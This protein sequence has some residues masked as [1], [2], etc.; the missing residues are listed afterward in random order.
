M[1]I[2]SSFLF[3][4]LLFGALACTNPEPEKQD[5]LEVPTHDSISVELPV[6]YNP[7]PSPLEIAWM[8]KNAGLPYVEGI[9]LAPDAKTRF[10]TSFQKQLGLGVYSAD[11]TYCSL[12]M[13]EQEAENYFLGLNELA[14]DIGFGETLNTEYNVERMR[15][16]VGDIDSVAF[17]L[18][19]IHMNTNRYF[20]ENNEMEKS[21]VIFSGAWIESMYLGATT[22]SLA[23][24][25]ELVGLLVEQEIICSDIIDG[26]EKATPT[27]NPQ[28]DIAALLEILDN[29]RSQLAAITTSENSEE[30]VVSKEKLN[31]FIV[32]L[33]QARSTIVNPSQL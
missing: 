32:S 3:L 4:G 18:A 13:M 7:L 26:L 30:L 20:K 24:N 29:L 25:P 14:N 9:T 33:K 15:R 6:V 1:T 8:F 28:N 17:L 11:L 22:T 31:D 27:E 10:A 16:S 21:F 12:N 23:E 5:T 19:E 2:Q